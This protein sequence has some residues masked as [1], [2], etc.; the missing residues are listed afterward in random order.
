MDEIKKTKLFYALMCLAGFLIILLP[1]GIANFYFGYVLKDSPC[2]LCWGQREAMIFIGVIALFI[3]RYG[4]KAKYLAMLLIVTAFGLWQSLAHYGNHAHRDLD[5]GFG[6]AVFGIHTYFWAEV[7]FW[8]VI[9]LLGIML[10]FAPKFSSFDKEMEG[11]TYRNLSKPVFVVFVISAFVIASNVFQAFVSTG[12]APYY[13]QGD[14]VRFTLDKKYI[15]WDDSGYKNHFKTISFLGKRDV[16]APDYAFAP[17]TKLGINFDN[18]PQNS[19]IAADESLSIKSQQVIE[20]DKPINT[21]DFIDGEFVASSKWDV[22]FMDENFKVNS[23]FE[24]DPLFSATI[25]PI[26]S[27][28]KMDERR[29]VL[30]GSNKTFLKFAKNENANEALQ[31]ADFIEGNDKFEGQGKGLGRGRIDT[32]RAKFH[33]IASMTN[34]GKYLYL[35]SVPNNKDKKKFVISKILMSDMTLSAEFTPSANLKDG[36][37]LGDL[38]ITS[39]TYY[40]NKIYALSKNHNVI[41]VINPQTQS[42]EKAVSYPS[43]IKN[44]RS[45]F[46]KDSE[47]QILSY[48]E[49]KNILFN[50]SGEQL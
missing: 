13:G 18:D 20:F 15:I 40:N 17:A 47:I 36:A 50:V 16:K 12:I 24:L 7:V 49:G 35:A 31:Y 44:A 34:D 37:S 19:P 38:Y 4:M 25:D 1:V 5:Q 6:L 48:Q 28:N 30:M 43:E 8:A 41:A 39:M 26:I 10:F 33:H 32:V 46:V 14:P 42:I 29:F 21:L 27:I 3:V 22:Y 45:I 11:K 2:T 9:L 23:H